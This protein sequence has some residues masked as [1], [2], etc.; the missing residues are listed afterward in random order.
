LP[1]NVAPLDSEEMIEYI[2]S[3]NTMILRNILTEGDPIRGQKLGFH[4]KMSLA[5]MVKLFSSH[6]S[7]LPAYGIAKRPNNRF[8]RAVVRKFKA[9][10]YL[11]LIPAPPT[12]KPGLDSFNYDVPPPLIYKT[13]ADVIFD[14]YIRCLPN[15]KKIQKWSKKTQIKYVSKKVQYANPNNQ[16]K[17][18][19]VNLLNAKNINSNCNGRHAEP[20]PSQNRGRS[21]NMNNVSPWQMPNI[22]YKERKG[23]L[24]AYLHS[25]GLEKAW[26]WK[27]KSQIKIASKKLKFKNPQNTLRLFNVCYEQLP[28]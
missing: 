11:K 17:T 10:K 28:P 16:L 24:R 9:D 21:N 8:M 25:V 20:E 19:L 15:G 27:L 1:E 22:P 3:V 7:D 6:Y 12:Q 4:H 18:E 23:Y 14:T 5:E 2:S 26:R 13:D